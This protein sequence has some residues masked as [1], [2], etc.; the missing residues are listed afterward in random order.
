MSTAKMMSQKSA[1]VAPR[2]IASPFTLAITGLSQSIAPKTM[3]FASRT[4]SEKPW[5]SFRILSIC[6]K[7]PPALNARPAPVSTR[8]SVSG[9]A[10]TSGNRCANSVCRAPAIAF[11]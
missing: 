10:A 9:S 8:T 11:S 1:T 6:D 3:R 5:G 2:P 4:A 7:S